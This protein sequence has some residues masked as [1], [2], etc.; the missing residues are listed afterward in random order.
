MW[1]ISN[2]LI[3]ILTFI[4]KYLHW[5]YDKVFNNELTIGNIEDPKIINTY[6]T[7]PVVF[8]IVIVAVVVWV[9][10]L[11]ICEYILFIKRK[12]KVNAQPQM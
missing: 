11:H 6:Y 5:N 9:H 10:M 7:P 1:Y 12:T 8:W 4:I 3:E 2:N